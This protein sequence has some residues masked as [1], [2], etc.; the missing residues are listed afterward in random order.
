MRER[1][2]AVASSSVW[3]PSAAAASPATLIVSLES[4]HILD[5]VP[6]RV[7]QSDLAEPVDEYRDYRDLWIL[8]GLVDCHVHLNEPGRT[9]WEGFRTGTI[10]A[11]SGGVTTLIDM[12]LNAIPPTTTV[13][14]LELKLAAATGQCFADVGFWGGVVPDN[15]QD[16]KPLV[17]AGV[18][19]FK[20]FLC[21]SGVEEFPKVNEEQVLV[22]MKELEATKSLF[23][24]HAELEEEQ[25]QEEPDA[26]ATTA[27]AAPSDPS[28][29]STFL[30]S[31][32][33]RLEDSAI[34]LILRC[35]AKHP[36]LRTHIVHLSAASA[37]PALRHARIEL[38][39]PITVETCFHYLCLASD[40][41]PQGE[42][43]YKCCPPIRDDR[44]RDALWEGLIDGTI[45]FVVSD[46]SPCV[47]ELK[48]LESGDFMRAWGGIGG[49]GLGL[50]L[51]WTEGQRRGVGFDR[52]VEWCSARPARQVGLDKT[53]G[54]LFVGADADFVVFDP[55]AHFT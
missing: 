27:T 37:L 44:N 52:V 13:E 14:N 24:F 55:D 39:L 42:T 16:L 10:A 4:G 28:S 8:P 48:H 6:G 43:L 53:K 19:G 23:L 9:E 46:H 2:L 45:D 22:A 40:A 21:E 49:L 1:R 54:G 47:T 5:V 7:A 31:R 50:S 34:A 11:V 26:A 41:V 32:P 12:P 20:S 17:D 38:Q 30:A 36:T 18:K 29:Y 15:A 35:A 51:L 33:S 25:G 3:L